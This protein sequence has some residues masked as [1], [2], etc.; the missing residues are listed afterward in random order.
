MNDGAILVTGAS[1]FVGAHLLDQLGASSPTAPIH[2]WSRPGGPS[3]SNTSQVQWR[4]V[5]LIDADD[6]TDAV[7]ESRPARVYHL[8]GAAHVGASWGRSTEHLETHVLGTHH[9]LEAIRHHAPTCRVLVVSSGMIYRSQNHAVT[10]AS[11]LGPASPYALSKLAEDQLALHAAAH[12]GLDIVVARPFNHIG[13]RQSPDFAASSF[14]RQIALIE[15]GARPATIAIGN[16]ETARDL[17]DVR[18]VA[19][20]YIALMRDGQRGTAYNVCRGKAVVMRDLLDRLLAMSTVTVTLEQDATRLRPNDLPFL[21]GDASRLQ[22]DTGW[23]PQIPLQQTLAD[24]L[25]FWRQTLAR[26]S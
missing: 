15:A 10:E 11:P 20:A 9:L 2:A 22:A 23:S 18:D 13:P 7:A 26:A 4:S 6:V 19:A 1:G 3:P 21:A 5:E 17:T 14:A 12:D 8:A 16:L 25:D 24:L